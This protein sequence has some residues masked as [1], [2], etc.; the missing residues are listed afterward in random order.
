MARGANGTREHGGRFDGLGEVDVELGAGEVRALMGENGAGPSTM[1]EIV[2]GVAQPD[3]GVIEW[4]GQP[5]VPPPPSSR[6]SSAAPASRS[7]AAPRRPPP[8]ENGSAE[9][10]G[11]PSALGATVSARDGRGASHRHQE[12]GARGRP[13]CV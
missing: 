2:A 12:G 3:A 6:P 8:G 4:F 5:V 7:K 11:E 10:W 13:L 9:G 1:A